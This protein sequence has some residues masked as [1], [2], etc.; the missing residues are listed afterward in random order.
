MSL[1]LCVLQGCCVHWVHTVDVTSDPAFQS[2]YRQGQIYRLKT[3]AY[4]V[5]LQN[6]FDETYIGIWSSAY[7][8]EYDAIPG[9][10]G[11]SRKITKLPAGTIIHI[12]RLTYSSD[13]YTFEA[14]C[15][16]SM[17]HRL[18]SVL[19]YVTVTSG[20]MTWTNIIAPEAHHSIPMRI[21]ETWMW[22]PDMDMIELLSPT[23][24]PTAR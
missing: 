19:A 10:K 5:A 22:P 4:L 12:D 20:S 3:S 23:T 2:G 18:Q 21:G 1:V 11:N 6:E 15:L 13:Q 14:L 16:G 17:N 24:Q 7:F 9:L 8:D